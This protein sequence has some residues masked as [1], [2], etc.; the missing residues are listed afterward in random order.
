MLLTELPTSSAVP[1]YI[2]E[3]PIR[4][5]TPTTPKVVVISS[6]DTVIVFVPS[7]ISP[8]NVYA[9]ESNICINPVL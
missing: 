9:D 6:Y 4:T 8:L 3:R 7:I 2:V 5:T 1:S